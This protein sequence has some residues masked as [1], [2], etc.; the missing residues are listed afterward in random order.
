MTRCSE[1]NFRVGEQGNTWD[2][3]NTWDNVTWNN[4]KLKCRANLSFIEKKCHNVLLTIPFYMNDISP[5][6]LL[7]NP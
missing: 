3:G 7:Y 2:S 5:D 4:S 1:D 6:S